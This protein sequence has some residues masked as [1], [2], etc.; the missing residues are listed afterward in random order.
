MLRM[1]DM[2]V[3]RQSQDDTWHGYEVRCVKVVGTLAVH[4]HRSG[5]RCWQ[6]CPWLVGELCLT[7]NLFKV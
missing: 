1:L 5:P 4:R 2:E 6:E 3:F 7:W